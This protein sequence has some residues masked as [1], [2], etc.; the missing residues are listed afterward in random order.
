MKLKFGIYFCDDEGEKFFGEGPYQLLRGIDELGSLRASAKRMGMAYTKAFGIL[1]RAE[2]AFAFPLTQRK[3][4]GRACL[5]PALR[6]RARARCWRSSSTARLCPA[7]SARW[8]AARTGFRRGSGCG[9]AGVG[10]A[11]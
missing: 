2:D 11:A 1:K 4:G 6:A 10:G 8:N 3:I 9:S 5:L 7:W